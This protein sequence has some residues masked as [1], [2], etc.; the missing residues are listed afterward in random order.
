MMGVYR[1]FV[2]NS[3]LRM[4]QVRIERYFASTRLNWKTDR[5]GSRDGNGYFPYGEEHGTPTGN[6]TYKFATYWRDSTTGLDY[7]Q[8]R[9]YA[10]TMGRFLT[11]DPIAAAN[12]TVLPENW[13][14]Y[15]YVS[16]DSVN[17]TDPLGLCSP[18]DNP[19]CYSVTVTSSPWYSM[20]GGADRLPT[21]EV[22][23]I[24]DTRYP[25]GAP[26]SG[27]YVQTPPPNKGGWETDPASAAKVGWQYLTSIWGDCLDLF[28]KDQR[29]DRGRFEKLLSGGANW[30]DTR[31]SDVG[32][33]TVDSVASNGDPTT[34]SKYVAGN[35]ARVI[36]GTN[37]VVLSIDWFTDLTQ[38][39]QVANTIHEALHIELNFDDAELQGWLMNFGFKD[40][41]PYGTGDGTDW[42]ASNCGRPPR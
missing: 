2:Y 27:E 30:W 26:Y 6:D 13:N 9:Y 20:G 17:K 15:A 34:L 14:K 3:T 38:T 10:S 42:I 4:E 39:Q 29:F 18:Q 32:R 21:Y 35:V 25:R 33:R 28:S 40:V 16:G 8:Q 1:P 11:P 36:N 37:H 19:P 22:V 31:K 7:A 24:G 41:D 23:D 12:A 5:L